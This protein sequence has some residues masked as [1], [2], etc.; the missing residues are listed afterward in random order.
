[1]LET[2]H[3]A[4]TATPEPFD[5]VGHAVFEEQWR[6]LKIEGAEGQSAVANVEVQNPQSGL[7]APGRNRYAQISLTREGTVHHLFSGRVVGAPSGLS[8]DFMTLSLDARFGDIDGAIAAAVAPYKVTPG[9]DPLFVDP[10]RI[11]EPMEVLEGYH[12]HLFVDHR[13]QAIRVSDALLGSAVSESAVT[14]G[15]GDISIEIPEGLGFAHGVRVR[16]WYREDFTEHFTGPVNTYVD[17]VLTVTAD[18]FAGDTERSDWVVS[19]DVVADDIE[20]DSLDVSVEHKP[21]TAVRTVIEAQWTQAAS[22]DVSLTQAIKAASGRPTIRTLS[23]PE[24]FA[25]NWPSPGDSVNGNSGYTVKTS[26]L[27]R[28]GSIESTGGILVNWNTFQFFGIKTYTPELTLTYELQQKRVE[29]AT[30]SLFGNA[31]D[32]IADL[33]QVQIE[34][35]NLQ[36]VGPELPAPSHGSFFLTDRGRAALNHGMQRTRVALAESQRCVTVGFTTVG[37]PLEVL[38]LS[39]DHSVCVHSPKLPGGL[40][41]GKVAQ[42][43]KEMDE[44]GRSCAVSLK[45]SAGKG[46]VLPAAENDNDYV[47]EDYIESGYFTEGGASVNTG[48]PTPIAYETFGDQAPVDSLVDIVNWT[49]NDFV[50]DLTIGPQVEDQLDY[51]IAHSLF[52]PQ[53]GADNTRPFTP[54]DTLRANIPTALVMTLASLASEDE[55]AHDFDVTMVGAYGLPKTIDLEA[56]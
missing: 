38:Y 28:Q 56:A 21:Y 22:G 17:G 36:D 11:D 46:Y 10:A 51:L 31:Q 5:P 27:V 29:R 47:D 26:S 42:Y 50:Q 9:F 49:Q 16:V 53:S 3:F 4:W 1:M 55:L 48:G 14:P 45:C 15:L 7:L 44:S 6:S 8:G 40:A 23:N 24:D 37:W 32:V 33:S 13:N 19:L 43:S 35:F 30:F 18:D 39:C 12:A 20:G 54:A 25:E 52:G 34:E 41:I 2:Q